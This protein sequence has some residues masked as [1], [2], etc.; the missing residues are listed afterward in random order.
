MLSADEYIQAVCGQI[1]WKKA[2]RLV[3]QE[4]KAHIEDQRDAYLAE[5]LSEGA[6]ARRAVESMGDPVAV[7]ASLDRVHRP[8]PQ[9]FMVALTAAL[10]VLGIA[11]RY[12]GSYLIEAENMQPHLYLAGT[13]AACFVFLA[14]Y[15][16]DFSWLG[17]Y[18]RQIFA[19]AAVISSGQCFL[20]SQS[21]SLWSGEFPLCLIYPCLLYTSRCV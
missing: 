16:L 15:F 17:K 2:R 14:A 12:F 5:G 21:G 18:S 20:L 19:A 6:A 8:K 9:Y 1:R 13:A 11:A 3:A 10:M 4:I 7:G